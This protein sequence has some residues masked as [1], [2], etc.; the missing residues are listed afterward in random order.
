MNKIFKMASL[1]FKRAPRRR[2]L[3]SSGRQG[4]AGFHN[5][6]SGPETGSGSKQANETSKRDEA[7]KVLSL[8]GLGGPNRGR[9]YYRS[10]DFIRITSS[11]VALYSS[12]LP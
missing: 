6:L 4:K 2:L 11:H 9:Q 1:E 8:H 10:L 5:S 3:L 7:A 12:L